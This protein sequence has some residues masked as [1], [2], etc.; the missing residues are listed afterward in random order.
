MLCESSLTAL[1]M[2]KF[3]NTVYELNQIGLQ[4]RTFSLT[5]F[6]VNNLTH[7]EMTYWTVK[8]DMYVDKN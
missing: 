8:G 4:S 5:P 3:E 1:K 7:I 2:G 6:V